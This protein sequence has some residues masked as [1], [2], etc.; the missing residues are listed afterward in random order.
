MKKGLIVF[1]PSFIFFI[2]DRLLKKIVLIKGGFLFFKLIPN[3]YFI[4]FLSG[5][6]FY[7]FSSLIFFLLIFFVINAYKRKQFYILPFLFYI[8]IGGFSNFLDRLSYG[9]V[10]D[11]FSFLNLFTFNFSDIM[12]LIGTVFSIINLFKSNVN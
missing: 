8:F 12:V 2:L 6:I 1:L 4:F 11:Y 3:Y 5:K 10:I 9:F 7:L